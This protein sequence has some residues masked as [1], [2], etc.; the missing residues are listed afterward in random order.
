[1]MER[2][3]ALLERGVLPRTALAG[4]ERWAVVVLATFASLPFWLDAHHSLEAFGRDVL[5]LFGILG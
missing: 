1:L 2:L 4:T 5:Q 3:H